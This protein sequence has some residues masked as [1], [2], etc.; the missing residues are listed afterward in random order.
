MSCEG[1]IDVGRS[2]EGFFQAEKTACTEIER[3]G[4]EVC[5]WFIMATAQI[6]RSVLIRAVAKEISRSEVLYQRRCSCPQNT[7][8]ILVDFKEEG[9]N[10][11]RNSTQAM[12][13]IIRFLLSPDRRPFRD[14]GKRELWPELRH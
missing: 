4:P 10:L 1:Q 5:K 6:V 9:H 11:F 13:G 3:Y 14:P 8:I 7:G 12:R 2:G